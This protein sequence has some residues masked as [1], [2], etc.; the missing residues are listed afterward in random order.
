MKTKAPK[1]HSEALYQSAMTNLF[2]VIKEVNEQITL[3]TERPAPTPLLK[4]PKG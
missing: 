2:A 3:C 4:G 1:S